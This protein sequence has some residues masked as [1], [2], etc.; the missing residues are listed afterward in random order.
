VTPSRRVRIARSVLRASASAQV[1]PTR[2]GRIL[3]LAAA[4]LAAGVGVFELPSHTAGGRDL[5]AVRAASQIGAH[6]VASWAAS[7]EP[8]SWLSP[9]SLRG[10]DRQ[11]LRQVIWTSV[12]GSMVRVQF[13]NLYGTRPLRIGAAGVALDPTGSARTAGAGIRLTF[14]GRTS[15]TIPPAAEVTSDPAQMAVAP[16]SDLAVSMEFSAPTGPATTHLA[17][18][19][20]NGIARGDHVSA[21]PGVPFTGATSSYFFLDRVSVLAAP[22]VH[23]TVV[24]LGD[25]LTDG[26]RSGLDANARWPNDLARRLHRRIGPTLSVVDAGIAGNR[27]LS[28]SP[29]YG[30]GALARIRRDALGA[31]GAREVILLEGINDIGMSHSTGRCS[32]PHRDVSA[33]QII[34]GD[35]QLVREA[36]AS[37]VR[38]FGGTLL[39]FRGSRYW[40]AA[41]EAQ[42]EAVNRWIRSSRAFD[43]VIDFAASVADPTDPEIVAPRYDSGDHLHLNDAGYWAMAG[44]VDLTMLLGGSTPRPT[45]CRCLR[46]LHHEAYESKRRRVA[47]CSRHVCPV[48]VRTAGRSRTRRRPP[49]SLL[50]HVRR[51][52][53]PRVA[54]DLQ[55]AAA[56]RAT[57]TTII[58][59]DATAFEG[60]PGVAHQAPRLI[61]SQRP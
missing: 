5:G 34:A 4:V 35:Q 52:G 49:P 7:P 43:G 47:A 40:T 19:Q 16:L 60:L 36:H 1:R 15:V 27:V 24:A 25:S 46:G 58:T 30:P 54:H 42:R 14:G 13:T 6:W 37:G 23:G 55:I 50:A 41:G 26:L 3:P 9:V 48:T 51:A 38:I 18:E 39:P 31:P 45:S 29:C 57:G 33:G 12:G 8:P 53:P 32:A 20:L 61:E 2:R 17:A 28:K 22:A 56:A 59:A 44:A 10:F 21:A 11:T